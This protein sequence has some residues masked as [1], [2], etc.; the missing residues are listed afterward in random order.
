MGWR[1]F[2]FRLWFEFQKK[3]GL[4]ERRFPVHA[5]YA[6]DYSLTEWKNNPPPFV[7]SAKANLNWTKVADP[8]LAEKAASIRKG[9]LPYFS[10]S[11][12]KTTGPDKWHINPDNNYLFSAETHWTRIP[13]LS[14]VSGDIKFVWERSRFSWLYTLILSDYH[15]DEDHGSWIMEEIMDWIQKNPVNQGPNWRCS[16][17][18]SLR[19][20]NWTYALCYYAG[21]PSLTEER[22]QLIMRHIYWQLHHVYENIHFSR[23]AVRNNHAITETAALML[24]EILFPFIPET[25]KWARKGRQWFEKEINYQIYSDGTYLQ[26]SHNYHRVVVQLFTLAISVTEKA[27]KPLA[28][29][30]YERA[31]KSLNFLYQCQAGK[32]GELPNYG[33]N[34]GALFFPL[35][36]ASDYR[37][38]RPQLNSLHLLL[39]GK[40]L[41]TEK[42]DWE[43]DAMHWGIG[44]VQRGRFEPL[45]HQLGWHQFPIGGFY[46]WREVDALSFIR[47]GNHRDRPSQADNLHLDIW[48]KGENYLIDAGTYKY[49]AAPEEVLYFSGTA[50]HNTVMVNGENQM[51]KGPR[52]IWLDWSQ[53]VNVSCLQTEDSSIFEGEI[54]AFKQLGNIS[55]KRIIKKKL[56]APQWEII[57]VV[58]G[59][60]IQEIEQIWHFQAEL[61]ERLELRSDLP[62]VYSNGWQSSYYGT[63]LKSVTNTIK[64]AQAEIKT[65][66]T[67]KD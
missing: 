30:I 9:E 44:A 29:S 12:I 38:Y 39:T 63:K 41:Y 27:A 5:K 40:P 49:N 67:I 56:T 23:I 20:F 57:D 22:F 2:G 32:G 13:D 61:A 54:L 65:W 7:V 62:I 3:T 46:I 48:Y 66:I 14:P 36:C 33:A 37:D 25:K 51:P 52:F 58:L 60:G 28:L 43:M 35:S 18:I 50:S 19:V 1:Y 10:S 26:F 21:H 59:N 53:S 6:L 16:Q 55:H 34:D 4:L 47:C 11:W 64:S 45:Q 17:E 15:N 24:S 8:I 42:G 31:Y